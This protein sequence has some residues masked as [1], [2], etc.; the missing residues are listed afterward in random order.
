MAFD[1]KAATPDTT[2]P[3]TGFLIGAD[4]QAATD[5]SLYS[6]SAV[7]SALFGNVASNIEF[8]AH[9]TYTLGSNAVRL[10]VIYSVQVTT[11]QVNVG[12]YTIAA[13]GIYFLNRF[14]IAAGGADG[15]VVFTNSPETAG[16]DIST[17]TIKTT[18]LTVATLPS[19]ATRGAGSRS[20]VTDANA[21][22]FA[23][24]VAGGGSNAVP[25]YSDGTD[26]RIG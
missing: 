23:T 17:R 8:G 18:A 21:A 14:S 11:S 7:S 9:N 19:A 2:L 13:N 22:T 12:N 25:V 6:F 15:E 4:S 26:W 1:V 24:V 3:T 10:A 20:F 16:A 5:P